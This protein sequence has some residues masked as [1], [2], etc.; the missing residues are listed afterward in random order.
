VKNLR[1][2]RNEKNMSMKALGD[3]IGVAESTISLYETGKRE[4][5]FSTIINI[6]KYFDVSIDYLMGLNEQKKASPSEDELAPLLQEPL[7]K[8]IYETALQLSPEARKIILAQIG[9][10]KDL[11][12]GTKK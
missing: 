2:L 9:A 1:N 12:A 4:P 6:A 3:S 11:E 8:E 5:D 7:M 10:V